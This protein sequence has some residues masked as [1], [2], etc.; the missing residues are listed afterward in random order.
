[1]PLT[2][3][4][5]AENTLNVYV[6]S[7]TP[8]DTRICCPKKTTWSTRAKM[9]KIRIIIFILIVVYFGQCACT[10]SWSIPIRHSTNAWKNVVCVCLM[11]WRVTIVEAKIWARYR[12]M[13]WWYICICFVFVH[14]FSSPHRMRCHW[15]Q[16]PCMRRSIR[17]SL[18]L[19]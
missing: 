16:I 2:H 14:R 3:F 8:T 1:M 12:G 7:Y 17:K 4:A 9:G 15:H 6:R 13:I 19:M 11:R 10:L 5:F 18:F